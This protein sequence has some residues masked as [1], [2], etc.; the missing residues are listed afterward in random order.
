LRLQAG[1]QRPGA[2]PAGLKVTKAFLRQRFQATQNPLLSTCSLHAAAAPVAPTADAAT[3]HAAVDAIAASSSSGTHTSSSTVAMS[4][5][6]RDVLDAATLLLLSSSST[7][8]APAGST[9]RSPTTPTAATATADTT[10]AVQQPVKT[11]APTNNLQQ[12]TAGVSCKPSYLRAAFSKL[13]ITVPNPP[14]SAEGST[15][16]PLQLVSSP[17]ITATSALLNGLKGSIFSATAMRHMAGSE[18]HPPEVAAPAQLAGSKAASAYSPDLDS[19]NSSRCTSALGVAEVLAGQPLTAIDHVAVTIMR[20]HAPF[21]TTVQHQHSHQQGEQQQQQQQVEQ[22]QD[23]QQDEPLISLALLLDGDRVRAVITPLQATPAPS[24]NTS[25]ASSIASRL[26][27]SPWLAAG[28]DAGASRDPQLA[29]AAMYGALL[30]SFEDCYPQCPCPGMS[31]A[32]KRWQAA[33]AAIIFQKHFGSSPCL[34][35][36]MAM[37]AE[38]LAADVLGPSSM[39]DLWRDSAVE[40]GGHHEMY[41]TAASQV[42]LT[43]MPTCSMYMLD[44]LPDWTAAL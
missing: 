17:S 32:R 25:P 4:S 39:V 23:Q 31:N 37:Q 18:L 26:K 43:I 6:E 41:G 42:C 14:A 21:T 19:R 11:D 28:G 7:T 30:D 29:A 13:K 15:D 44:G 33:G 22:E 2:L 24:S 34:Q 9:P 10:D 12:S 36:E 35:D 16:A 1:A 8:A 27:S 20:S 38:L 40:A 3:A 5:Q